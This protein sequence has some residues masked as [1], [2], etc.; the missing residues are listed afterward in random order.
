MNTNVWTFLYILFVKYFCY[1]Y[2]QE[3]NCSVI[4]YTIK[5]MPIYTPNC[6]IF[7]QR[8]MLSFLNFNHPLGVFIFPYA[9]FNCIIFVI[10]LV[11]TVQNVCIYVWTFKYAVEY[12]FIFLAM[13]SIFFL[14][15]SRILPDSLWNVCIFIMI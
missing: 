1:A 15:S 12:F 10:T 2:T 3:R 6:S 4:G 5:L 11:E 13:L 7:I 14:W 8:L 9:I